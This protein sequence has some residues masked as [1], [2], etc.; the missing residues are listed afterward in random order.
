ML[1][2][3]LLLSSRTCGWH[4]PGFRRKRRKERGER[5]HETRQRIG[6]A[7]IKWA[8]CYSAYFYMYLLASLTGSCLTSV[9][10]FPILITP[11]NSLEVP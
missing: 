10:T 6:R 4:R 8:E 3:E 11:T 7:F 9:H 1:P 5:G 2:L